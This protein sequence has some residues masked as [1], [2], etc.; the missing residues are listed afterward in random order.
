MALDET[1]RGR[2]KSLIGRR[3]ERVE[4][5]PIGVLF[6]F[7]GGYIYWANGKRVL[8]DEEHRTPKEPHH[9]AAR[10]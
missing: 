9:R 10:P 8:Q 6:H 2:L 5:A 1:A 7:E 3:L 4:F